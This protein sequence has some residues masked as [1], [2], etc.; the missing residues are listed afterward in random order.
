MKK[1]IGHCGKY[2]NTPCLSPQILHKHCFCFLL[3]PFKSHEKLETVLMQNLGEQ[4]KSIMVFSGVPY[5]ILAGVPFR[6]LPSRSRAFVRSFFAF[7]SPST[8][9]AQASCRAETALNL[10]WHMLL[11]LTANLTNKLNSTN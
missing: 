11:S 6:P 9:A 2:H 10:I 5:S 7:P 3:G 8:P 4:T 1:T